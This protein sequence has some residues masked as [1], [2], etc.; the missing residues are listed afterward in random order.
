MSSRF[1]DHLDLRVSDL[2]RAR[3]FYDVFI[4][5]LGFTGTRTGEGWISYCLEADGRTT[6]FVGL[7]RNPL[8]AATPTVSPF[9]P[10]RSRR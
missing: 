5:A 10:T 8:I 3:E 9:G 4:P 2:A 6:P 1:F 7:T